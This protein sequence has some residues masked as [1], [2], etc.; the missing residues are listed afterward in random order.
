MDY[1]YF[2]MPLHPPGRSLTDGYKI[3]IEQF[4]MADQMGYSEGW[5]GEHFTIPWESHPAPDLFV[6]NVLPR[7]DQIKLG[8]G[9]VLLP[10]HDPRLVALR[11]AYLDHL[12]EGRFMFGIGSGGA[13]TDF[14]WWDIDAENGQ[15]REMFRESIDA[16]LAIWAN[17]GP[18]EQKG[19]YWN[20]TIPAP[21]PDIPLHHHIF[22]YQKP[23][24]PIAVAGLHRNSETLTLAGER[25]W[26][27]MSINYLPARNLKTH[28]DTVEAGAKR[29]G[30][31]APSRKEWRIAREVYVAETDEKAV[32]ECLNGPMRAAYEGYMSRVLGS[33]G[34][35]ELYKV[36]PDM[37]D[38]ELTAEYMIEHIWVVG[39]PDTVAK[40]LEKL[41]HDVD[42]YG[43]VL[44]I[45]YDWEPN[46]DRWKNGMELFTKEVM[47]GLAHLVPDES[48]VE[49]A[50]P[51]SG[52]GD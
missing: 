40:K 43:S 35:L 2:S 28:W 27:P 36:D 34:A 32:E 11:I 50:V 26:I 8:T 17:E 20:Y 37:P 39:S 30:R 47:P 48:G 7:T 42:G 9:V 22:P 13:P 12:A 52:G 4:V 3:D 41:Y 44:Q 6:A 29:A 33:F 21:M 15:H 45:G 14:G 16:I 49:Q 10:M 46:G 5:M 23:H 38:S 1:G 19:K 31:S 25:G 24:P 51:A 18:Y